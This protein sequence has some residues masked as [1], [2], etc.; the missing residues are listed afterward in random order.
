MTLPHEIWESRRKST[1]PQARRSRGTAVWAGSQATGGEDATSGLGAS[2]PPSIQHTH[3]TYGEGGQ[4]A[5]SFP[6]L[7]TGATLEGTVQKASQTPLVAEKKQSPNASS[8]LVGYQDLP[9]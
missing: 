8:E 6:D 1:S 7:P 4:R 5:L 3:S 9:V 2:V